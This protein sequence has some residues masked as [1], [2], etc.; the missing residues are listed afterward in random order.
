MSKVHLPVINSRSSLR[1][2]GTR[3]AIHPAD[4]KGRYDVARRV[5]F[6]AL[7][8]LWI[9]L[10][11]IEIG[12][13]PAVF[14][15][16]EARR[17]FLFG[18]S[19]NA[20][21]LWLLFFLVTGVAFLLVYMTALL[22]RV[23]CGWI[24]PHTV[25]L[26]GVYRKIERFI[27][28]PRE[29]RIKRDAG[30]WTAEKIAVKVAKHAV[31]L[32][33]S[34]LIAH[35]VLSYFVSIPRVFEMVRHRPSE[36]LEAFI[37][38]IAITLVFYGHF[39]FFREQLCLVVCP[40]GRLQSVMIDD[41][42]MVVGYDERRGEPRG[43][44]TE[45]DKGDCVDCLRCVVVCPTG[46]DIRDG[47]Q[48]DCTGCTACID[49]CDEVMDKLE[50]PRGLIRYDSL[51]G[52]ARKKKRVLRPRIFLYTGLLVVGAGVA[53]FAISGRSDFEA[54]L[55]RLSAT[56]PFVVE[57]GK[58]RNAFEVHLVNKQDHP[59]AFEIRP[60]P[61]DGVSFVVPLARVTVGP[62]T[63]VHAPVFVTMDRSRFTG[64]F[65][66]EVRIV[67]ASGDDE[68]KLATAPFLGPS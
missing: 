43:K 20:Q 59:V 1:G 11:W 32:I 64:Q 66:V 27:E 22:G 7:I 49:A 10:P 33:V 60:E 36:H 3:N 65:P 47:L 42:S 68:G 57:D 24:C 28:G 25:F 58:V 39:T 53:L 46:I 16:V 44:A 34:S 54:N 17:F 19:F 48:L 35:I 55:L 5:V 15:D 26:D 67:K 9:A 31:F 62:M 29:R 38:A 4:V 13:N 14:L 30:A 41:D 63:S 2:D 8:A 18:L 37:W 40:Y 61:V 23:F 56:A 6:A 45:Q 50:R 21:D 51:N 52:L 12:G